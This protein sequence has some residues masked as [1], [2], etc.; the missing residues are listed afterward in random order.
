MPFSGKNIRYVSPP[1]S[2]AG[3]KAWQVVYTDG[4]KRTVLEHR[5]VMELF[6]ARALGPGEIVHHKNRNK[7]DNRLENLELTTRRAHA[8]HHA[9]DRPAPIVRLTCLG[10]GAEF[11]R[12]ERYER[13][14]RVSKGRHG[15]FCGKSCGPRWARQEHIKAGRINLGGGRP[16]KLA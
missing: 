16:K 14:N 11:T 9:E 3:Y 6:L 10:R 1:W 15:P 7:R 5:L 8:T 12:L 13:G 4:S 2:L